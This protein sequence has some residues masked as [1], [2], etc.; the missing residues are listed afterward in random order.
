MIY[1]IRSI[2][3][4]ELFFE[5]L[6]LEG[7]NIHPDDDF[8][9]IVNIETGATT[10]STEEI[11]LRNSLMRKSFSVCK[12]ASVDI[13]DF[14]MTIFLNKSGLNKLIPLPVSS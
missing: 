11:Q 14:G 7:T 4:V 1:K 3:D 9:N 5:C 10:Y 2:K 12:E 6:F 13:Y 8:Q